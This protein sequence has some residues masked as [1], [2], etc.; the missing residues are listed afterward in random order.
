MRSRAPSATPRAASQSR[1][2]LIWP[3]RVE[4][5]SHGKRW[6]V[7]WRRLA[8]W[9]VLGV[10]TTWLSIAAGAYYFIKY[11]VGFA[12]VRFGQIVLLPLRLDQYKRAKGEFWI[13]EGMAATERNQ[14]RDAF[15]LLRVG[16]PAVPENQEARI[17]VARIY[18]MAGRPDQAGDVLIEGI[19]Y[20]TDKLSYG[21]EVVGFLFTVQADE[22]VLSL[23][24]KLLPQHPKGDPLR[25]LLIGAKM[26]AHYNRDQFAEAKELIA[27]EKA[28]SSPQAKLVFA[29]IDWDRG[30]ESYALDTLRSLTEQNP[31]DSE[32]YQTLTAYLRALHQHGEIRRISLARQLKLPEQP[33]AYLDFIQAC[34]D[35]KDLVRQEQ[36]ET[37]FLIR[38]SDQATVLLQLAEYASR[39]GRPTVASAVL[40]RCRALVKEEANATLHLVSAYL[41]TRDYDAALSTAAIAGE[42]AKRWNEVQKIY[43]QGLRMVALA[44]SGKVNESE[45]AQLPI[46]ESRYLTAN[47]ATALATRLGEV[48]RADAA[49]KF[50]E[51]AVAVDSL[52][53]PAVVQLLRADLKTKEL[54]E[55]LPLIERFT[56]LR[57]PPVDLIHELRG[58]FESDRSL[59]L[60]DRAAWSA[61]LVTRR[62]R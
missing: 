56:T 7:S 23:C 61:R 43:L 19:P 6:H 31:A 53:Q 34:A 35:Q 17:M 27:A 21:R 60:P 10:F 57:K 40:E 62:A 44:G 49:R 58:K 3:L 18:L 24:D 5:T 36:A 37:E 15:D 16:L 14:W 28:E 8:I 20:S 25:A 32:A 4:K 50:L 2:S 51:R 33:Q 26:I 41:H 54:P 38:F 39:N 52:Y 29:R 13:R 22:A 12:D 46:L 48:E 55:L 30:L 1:L 11:Q 59:F 45:A 47:I 9:A 42:D